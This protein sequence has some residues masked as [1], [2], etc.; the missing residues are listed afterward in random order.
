MTRRRARLSFEIRGPARVLRHPA[1]FA[2]LFIKQN[3]K[4]EP[5]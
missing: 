4:G 2:K 1:F 5:E 3:K